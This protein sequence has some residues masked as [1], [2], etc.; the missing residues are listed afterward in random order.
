MPR[1]ARI[2]AEYSDHIEDALERFGDHEDMSS[3][4][5][6]RWL[7]QFDDDDL[8]LAAHVLQSI[9]YINGTNIRNMTRDLFELTQEE[10]GI[11]GLQKAAFIPVGSPGSGSASVA[12]VLRDAV[13]HSDHS[14]LSM[15]DLANAGADDFDA[16]VFVDDFSGTG[17]TLEKW[18]ENVESLVLPKNAEVFV[19]LLVLNGVARPR[20]ET[21]ADILAVSELDV[22]HNTLSQD[23][24]VFTEDQKPTLREY[25]VNTGVS[26]KY[27]FGY[28]DCALLMAFKH[29]CPNNSLPI[30]WFKGGGWRPLFNRRA[31]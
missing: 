16:I 11:K 20:I 17:E 7:V 26:E 13:R 25:C 30:L 21:F 24:A 29:G 12:R 14:V 6:L 19:G 27:H 3:G 31:I 8:P 15:L 2:E 23:S 9:S 22:T 10:L 18:W 1:A 4:R 5:I 28:G